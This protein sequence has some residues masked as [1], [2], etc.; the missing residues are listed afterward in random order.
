MSVTVDEFVRKKVL[1]EHQP[2]VKMIRQLMR[3]MAPDALETISYN[4]P[5]WKGKRILAWIIP[6]KK[7]ITFGF[8]RGTRFKDKYGLLRGV[9]KSARHIKL[10]STKDVDKR[11]LS[12]YI[13]QALALDT[14]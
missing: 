8:T 2:A 9:G 14:E 13:K 12:Y 3:E 11:V 1:P 4:M 10:K 5:V 6:T 7:D